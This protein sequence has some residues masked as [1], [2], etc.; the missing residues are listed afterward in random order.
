[1]TLRKLISIAA[2]AGTAIFGTA[3]AEVNVGADAY[4]RY[5]WRGSDIGDAVSVQPYMSYTQG[6]MEVGA[7]SAWSITG[8]ANENDLYATYSTGPVALTV[9]DYYNPHPDNHFLDYNSDTGAHILEA[10][11]SCNVGAVDVTGAFNF[12]GDADDSYYVEVGLPVSVLSDDAS[13]VSLTLGVGNGAYVVERDPALVVLG[14]N[15][16]RGDYAASYIVNPDSEQSYLVFGRG[17]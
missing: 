5:V 6:N 12:H 2:L 9:T 3:D 17:W 14:L 13:D 10:M 8:S 4:T 1:M 15:F 7:W 16:S 11:A